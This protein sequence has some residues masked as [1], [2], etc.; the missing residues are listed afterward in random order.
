MT[1]LKHPQILT[2]LAILST[3]M[4]MRAKGY[5]YDEMGLGCWAE[6]Q[7]LNW[8]MC[9]AFPRGDFEEVNPGKWE[10]LCENIRTNLPAEVS[11]PL[12]AYH[13]TT[14]QLNT[15]VAALKE[16]NTIRDLDLQWTGL[17]PDDVSR[18]LDAVKN[19][20]LRLL[21]LS[22]NAMSA[23]NLEE[24]GTFLTEH[25][26]MKILVLGHH[27][28]QK[29]SP[30]QVPQIVSRKEIK[31]FTD[32]LRKHK[33]LKTLVLRGWNITTDAMKELFDALRENE[34]V[35]C[36]D[37]QETFKNDSKRVDLLVDYLASNPHVK[38]IMIW[39]SG[40]GPGSGKKIA[41][42]MEKNTNL[43]ELW[44]GGNNFS[45]DDFY[46]IAK[47][48]PK[49]KTL[50]VLYCDGERDEAVGTALA[51][52]MLNNSS[53]T[54]AGFID[55]QKMKEE[56]IKTITQAAKFNSKHEGQDITLKQWR[57]THTPDPR[58]VQDWERWVR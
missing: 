39:N 50:K 14:N 56:D 58:N 15:F 42:A 25:Q 34:S 7:F 48:L 51:N 24:V 2:G 3:L 57:E 37:M 53:I 11:L 38:E 5:R 16:N 26:G 49:N 22:D 31:P 30:E 29:L 18:V 55:Y 12:Y 45:K 13:L 21:D 54:T 19:N 47:M 10:P 17:M 8:H 41:K 33:G 36:L 27:Y 52:A 6:P 35:E 32:A 43:R 23:K 28:W 9:Q 40:L 20:D 44:T 4:P 46:A 1:K